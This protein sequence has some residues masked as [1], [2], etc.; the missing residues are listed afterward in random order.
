M[1]PQKRTHGLGAARKLQRTR[2]SVRERK[3]SMESFPVPVRSS[4]GG[5]QCARPPELISVSSFFDVLFSRQWGARCTGAKRQRCLC[6]LGLLR[7]AGANLL[8]VR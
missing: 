8:G 3:A 7:W 1:T 6:P 4:G 2:A 5:V